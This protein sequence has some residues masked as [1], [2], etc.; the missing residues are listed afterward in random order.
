MRAAPA[1]LFMGVVLVG[2]TVPAAGQE[3][4]PLP[5]PAVADTTATAIAFQRPVSPM[6][7]FWRSFL[8]PGWGQAKLNRRLSGGLFIAV[9]GLAIGM[10]IKSSHQL[11]YLRRTNSPLADSK[12][13]QLED[14][15][16]ILVF[17]HLMS[18]L[19][20]FVS[21]HLWDFPDDLEVRSVPGAYGAQLTIPIRLP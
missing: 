18:G 6:G 11:G 3:L 8:I 1:V 20:A 5:P 14:W 21:A 2:T 7:A 10:I 4:T 9:E 16:T 12:E 15:V 13:Q 19:E 17:N